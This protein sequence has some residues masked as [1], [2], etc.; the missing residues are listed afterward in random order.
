[1][2]DIGKAP[3]WRQTGSDLNPSSTAQ[4]NTGGHS[5]QRMNLQ[6]WSCHFAYSFY[7]LTQGKVLVQSTVHKTLAP[8]HW[9]C[10]EWKCLGWAVTEPLTCCASRP[11]WLFRSWQYTTARSNDIYR[12]NSKMQL[13][14]NT[15]LTGPILLPINYVESSFYFQKTQCAILKG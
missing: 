13:T 12:W 5:S 6:F 3:L 14:Q 7:P 11:A 9:I 10:R 8:C 2:R 15:F 4:G 1:M